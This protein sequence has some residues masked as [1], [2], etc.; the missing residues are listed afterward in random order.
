MNPLDA[1]L[2]RPPAA[3]VAATGAVP[4]LNGSAAAVPASALA[5]CP[6]SCRTSFRSE[7]AAAEAAGR[8]APG[9][10]ADV[11]SAGADAASPAAPVDVA[12]TAGALSAAAVDGS[13]SEASDDPLDDARAYPLASPAVVIGELAAASSAPVGAFVS[14]SPDGMPVVPQGPVDGGPKATGSSLPPAI[15]VDGNS[16]PPA[17]ALPTAAAPGMLRS[18]TADLRAEA[19]PLPG[20]LRPATPL[21]ALREAGGT[22]S[23]ELVGRSAPVDAVSSAAVRAAA[24][25]GA[26]ARPASTVLPDSIRQPIPSAAEGRPASPALSTTPPAGLLP[27]A[28][29]GGTASAAEVSLPSAAQLEPLAGRGPSA[30]APPAVA[31][32]AAA[33]P[34]LSAE[35]PASRAGTLEP[36]PRPTVS[37][38]G[39][40]QER[41]RFEQAL[42]RN[43]S[44]VARQDLAM[45]ESANQRTSSPRP[46]WRS[47]TAE[48][49][50]AATTS[51]EPLWRPALGAE[52]LDT[53]A[54]TASA[55]AAA[56]AEQGNDSLR[57]LIDQAQLIM[58][59]RGTAAT[60]SL[61]L[62]DLGSVDVNLRQ[63]SGQTHLN[64]SVRDAAARE[65]LE[66]Q[67]PRL[68][69][70]FEQQGLSLGDVAMGFSDRSADDR[71]GTGSSA[72]ATPG[73][74]PLSPGDDAHRADAPRPQG[75][76]SHL[77]DTHA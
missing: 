41:L 44:G 56:A 17:P 39:S 1:L 24:P 9:V 30:S 10:A 65:A 29:G 59:R 57:R 13:G 38:A 66:A 34:D 60:L 43:A 62:D 46:F 21:A 45:R 35:S 28:S 77:I 74:V 22:A 26:P 63:E 48:P 55:A 16:L 14:P 33:S 37:E 11:A 8:V 12:P 75:P 64:F 31:A 20:D 52:T 54:V 19:I 61:T 47:A 70:L 4:S 71:E 15:L 69:A 25:D 68:R 42:T 40:Q 7:L 72:P 50:A 2:N 67:L 18:A 53:R 73:A 76:S 27:T 23:T 58:H 32:A 5:S 51:G 36:V 49:P 6:D 3:A